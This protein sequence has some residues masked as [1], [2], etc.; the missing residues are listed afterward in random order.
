MSAL[1]GGVNTVAWPKPMRSFLRRPITSFQ[2]ST[3]ATLQQ[4]I[5]RQGSDIASTDQLTGTLV[6]LFNPRTQSWHDHFAVEDGLIVPLTPAGRVTEK[7]LKPNLTE[8]VEV[9]AE[10]ARRGLWPS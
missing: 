1:A 2:K 4:R 8:R 10:L 9:R 3:A 7:I 6:Y 5:W